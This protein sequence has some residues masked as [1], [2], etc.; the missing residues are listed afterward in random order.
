[1]SDAPNDDADVPMSPRTKIMAGIVG[2]IL[3]VG[4]AYLML[5]TSSPT[6]PLGAKPPADHFSLRCGFCHREVPI[7]PA[8]VKP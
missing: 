1:M 4:A 7:P 2:A 8:A 6:I 3:L 5:R